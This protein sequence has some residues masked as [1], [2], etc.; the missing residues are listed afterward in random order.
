[1]AF[2]QDSPIRIERFTGNALSAILCDKAKSPRKSLH[3][4]LG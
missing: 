1:M 3:D 2:T 4:G